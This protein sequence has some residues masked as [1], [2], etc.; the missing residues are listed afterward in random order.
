MC[1]LLSNAKYSLPTTENIQY[2]N[3]C[4]CTVEYKLDMIQFNIH[5]SYTIILKC[6]NSQINDD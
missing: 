1:E 3:I 2:S 4:K 5:P 6:H